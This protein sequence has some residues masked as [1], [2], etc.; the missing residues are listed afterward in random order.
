MR[1]L[2][3]TSDVISNITGEEPPKIYFLFFNMKKDLISLLLLMLLKI[4]N[5]SLKDK[6]KLE[7]YIK[8]NEFLYDL[9][10]KRN[11]GSKGVIEIMKNTFKMLSD[12]LKKNEIS[13]K[14]S[15]DLS[16][17]VEQMNYL[18]KSIYGLKYEDINRIIYITQ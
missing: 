2:P 18:V 17:M 6:L 10:E 11:I 16:K 13:E 5:F 9:A 12:D 3:N 1:D 4:L 15:A 8:A 14:T 7:K